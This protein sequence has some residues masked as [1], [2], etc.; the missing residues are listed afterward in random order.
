MRFWYHHIINDSLAWI[1]ITLG[2]I[3]NGRLFADDI[4]RCIFLN[5]NVWISIKISLQFV[6][7]GTVN[8]IP[9]LVQIMTWRRPG[10]KSL[11]EPMVVRLPT[12]ICVSRTQWVKMRSKWWHPLKPSSTENTWKWGIIYGYYICHQQSW[13]WLN[14]ICVLW[15]ICIGRVNVR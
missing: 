15:Y 9:A 8:N 3:Q 12:D 10:G 4:F 7:K 11:S 13:R 14:P 6:P 2:L 5:A 1:F